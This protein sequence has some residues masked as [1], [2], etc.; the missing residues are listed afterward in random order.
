MVNIKHVNLICQNSSTR[1][2]TQK[3]SLNCNGVI[4]KALYSSENDTSTQKEAKTELRKVK[5]RT[6]NATRRKPPFRSALAWLRFDSDKEAPS[7][8]VNDH[9]GPALQIICMHSAAI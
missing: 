9:R 7:Y 1:S 8:Y 6:D 2:L 5:E 3:E 4:L